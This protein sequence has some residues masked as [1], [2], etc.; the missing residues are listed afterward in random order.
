MAVQIDEGRE[1]CICHEPCMAAW[2]PDGR[3]LYLGLEPPSRAGPGKTVAIPVPAGEML[4]SF[5][6]RETRTWGK[7]RLF[8]A[9]ASS[10]DGESRPDQILQCLL[11]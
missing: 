11:S 4:P 10:M 6:G 3:F 9:H 8:G 2:A 5:P 7:Q 1:R